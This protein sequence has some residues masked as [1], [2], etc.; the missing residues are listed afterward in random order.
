[1]CPLSISR[2]RGREKCYT[3]SPDLHIGQQRL[4]VG[5]LLWIGQQHLRHCTQQSRLKSRQSTATSKSPL[6]TAQALV[7]T[8]V[9]R[10][11]VED[12]L[13]LGGSMIGYTCITHAVPPLISNNLLTLAAALAG[14][15]SMIHSWHLSLL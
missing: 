14:S 9:I 7:H 3:I 13:H 2:T 11:K 12:V 10:S 6:H 4:K 5:S 1:M 15:R 8:W